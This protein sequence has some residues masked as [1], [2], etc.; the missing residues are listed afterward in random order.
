M[1]SNGWLDK[2]NVYIYITQLSHKKEWNPLFFNKM[3]PT[4]TI[5]LSVMIQPKIHKYHIFSLISRGQHRIQWNGHFKIWLQCD[6]VM[7]VLLTLLW[8]QVFFFTCSGSW[9]VVLKLVNIKLIKIFKK[10]NKKM[11]GDHVLFPTI[12]LSSSMVL[13]T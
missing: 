7:I 13:V 1:S 4:Q 9:F 6:S 5:M 8:N 10:R 12:F 3:D 11:N 2:Q